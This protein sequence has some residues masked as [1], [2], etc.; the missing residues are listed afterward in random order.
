MTSFGDLGLS[1]QILRALTAE[2]YTHPTPI[3]TQTIPPMLSGRDVLGIA[4]TGTGKTAAFVLPILHN[5][6]K[7]GDFVRHP[8]TCRALIL[9]PTRELAQQITENAKSYCRFAHYKIATVVGGVKAGK[10]IA[11]MAKGVDILIATPGRLFDL[12]TSG[13]IDLSHTRVCVM[14]E[15]DQM[16][17]LGF[18]PTI[19]KIFAKLP[20]QRQSVLMSATMPKQ[21]RALAQG[22]QRNPVE[23]SVAPTSRPIERIDQSL[24]HINADRKKYELVDILSNGKDK[25][26]IIFTRTKR[27]ADRVC[28]HLEMNGH[29]SSAIHGD[30]SQSQRE[31]ALKDFKAGIIPTLVATD[32]AARGID[33]DDV[34]HV[35]NFELPNVPESYVHR[36]GR[37]ARAGRSGTAIS[38]CD[39]SESKQLKDIQKLIGMEIPVVGGKPMNRAEK[40]KVEPLGTSRRST[41]NDRNRAPTKNLRSKKLGGSK[42]KSNPNRGP[43][44][45]RQAA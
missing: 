24:R 2:G 35:I 6:Q 22:F 41:K 17:D 43:K 38:L 42:H 9:A 27:G 18:F 5:L 8:K 11:T 26:T 36:I 15:A 21:I 10:Q 39:R 37:T 14:D 45:P 29:K 34:S 4:Q 23:V 40:V 32:I 30:K 12:N 44:Q 1:E 16:L 7:S 3:Q 28:K 31:R 19:K 25:R 33:I 13:A 20:S